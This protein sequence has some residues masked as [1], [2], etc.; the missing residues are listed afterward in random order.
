M[1]NRSYEANCVREG[2]EWSGSGV[3]FCL[4]LAGCGIYE[5][6][7]EWRNLIQRWSDSDG[8]EVRLLMCGISWG[9]GLSM[10]GSGETG[11][12]GLWEL[13]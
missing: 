6:V 5:S 8:E 7:D 4:M 2:A 9:R 1:E 10:M 12:V 3:F 13:V 11:H